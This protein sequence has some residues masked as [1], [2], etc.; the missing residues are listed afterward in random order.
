MKKILL[1]IFCL[2]FYINTNAQTSAFNCGTEEADFPSNFFNIDTTDLNITET[3]EDIIYV[4]KIHFYQLNKDDGTNDFPLDEDD[5]L[6]AI[7]MLN[8]IYN[9]YHIYFKWDNY[10]YINSTYFYEHNPNILN[11][12][13]VTFDLFVTDPQNNLYKE[14]TINV[15]IFNALAPGYIGSAGR[16]WNNPAMRIKIRS[17]W[18][19]HPALAHEAGHILGLRHTFGFFGPGNTGP[20]ACEHVTRDVDNLAFNA[21]S[22]GDRLIQ[23]NA[24]PYSSG[25]TDVLLDYDCNYIGTA[26]DC[27]GTPY[28]DPEFKNIMSYTRADCFRELTP[29]QGAVMRRKIK[30]GFLGPLNASLDTI[31]RKELYKPYKGDYFVAG[32]QLTNG[33]LF[34]RGFDYEFVKCGGSNYIYNEPSL[35]EDITW[36]YSYVIS[37][38]S[39][40]SNLQLDIEH[41]NHTAIRILQIDG[42]QPR[43][44][45]NNYNRGAL[46]GS[47]IKFNDGYPNTNVTITPKDSLGINQP[48]LIENLQPG[49]YNII[50]HYDDG[51]TEGGLILKNNGG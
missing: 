13:G 9:Q 31:H 2:S 47:V 6:N 29:A 26:I 8:Q 28:V 22:K 51:T 50:K 42:E 39:S 11:H 45:Y 41:P 35:Y 18:F 14:Q 12:L 43:K 3:D 33:P 40:N 49:L 15:Y 25:Y 27:E 37:A 34:Q 30:T 16:M 38:F 17:D 36:D 46:G 7:A 19:N 1:L 48:T 20:N 5:F 4:F 10:E 32:P 23:T 24:T 21:Y 44:C